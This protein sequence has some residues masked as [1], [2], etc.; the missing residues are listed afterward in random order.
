VTSHPSHPLDPPLND[1]GFILQTDKQSAKLGYARRTH[2]NAT[3][4]RHDGV[5][6]NDDCM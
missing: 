5:D 2:S 1:E 4:S 6:E 3:H